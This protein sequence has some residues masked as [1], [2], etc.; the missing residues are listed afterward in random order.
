M[1]NIIYRD[2]SYKIIGLAMTVHKE[3]GYGFLEKVYENALM[4]LFE[5]S[6]ISANQQEPINIHFRDKII[7][8]YIADIV[9]DNLI[10]LE[11]KCVSEISS[12]HKAQTANY[13]KATGIKLGI[14]LNFGKDSLEFQRVVL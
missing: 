6:G 12:K 5:E 7:G 9:V 13:L 14:I 2:L 11:L 3:L 1:D 10:I 8:S 4:V